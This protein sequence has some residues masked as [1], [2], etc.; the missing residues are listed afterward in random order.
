VNV[1]GRTVSRAFA[2]G[3]DLEGME[4]RLLSLHQVAATLM[5]QNRLY[6]NATGARKE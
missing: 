1:G 6:T 4:R 3:A 5:R 2:R